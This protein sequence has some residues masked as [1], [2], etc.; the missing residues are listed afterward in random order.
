[1]ALPHDSGV[2]HVEWRSSPK[3][4]RSK[5]ARLP[6]VY[7]G[8]GSNGLHATL[9]AGLPITSASLNYW[10]EAEPGPKPLWK[11]GAA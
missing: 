3:V 10:N 6:T 11:G 4:L 2:L 1:V 9:A 7:A 8:G 5:A